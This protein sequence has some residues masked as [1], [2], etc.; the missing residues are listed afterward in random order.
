MTTTRA[1]TRRTILAGAAMQAAPA[2]SPEDE[3]AVERPNLLLLMTDQQSHEAWSGAGNPYL[4]TPAMDSLA[5]RGQ[6]FTNAYCAYPVCSPSRSS[7]FTSRMP[8]ETGVEVNGRSIRAGMPTMGEVFTAAGYQTV[9]AGKWHLPKPFD[10]MTAFEK[11][12]GGSTYGKDMDEP[13]AHA[14]SQWLRRK[15]REPFLM[16]ASFMN[17]H[18]I[19]EW[20]RQHKGTRSHANPRRFPPAPANMGLEAGEPEAVRFHR[21]SGYDTMSQAVAIAA[22]WWKNDVR[23]YLHDYYRMV[24]AVDHHIGTVLEALR[25]S[26]LAAKTV[27]CFTSDHGEGLG[28][29]RWVQ[30]ASL[31]EESV[32]VPFVLAGP[33]VRRGVSERLVSLLDILPTLCGHAGINGPEEMRGLDLRT[34]ASR[35]Y[36]V[37]ELRYRDEQRDGRMVRSERYKYIVFRTGERAEQ[38][39]DLQKDP[40]E[41]VNLAGESSAKQELERHRAMLSEWSRKTGDGFARA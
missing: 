9:Y 33:G 13:V 26:G 20:I 35:P 10:G 18:D 3:A 27:V 29:H 34:E 8:H 30:K 23:E 15:P 25:D 36:V 1:F 37:S 5:A 7:I 14:C 6:V 17:P 16:V 4:K 2:F 21:T 31:Y 19:C 11:L 24:E 28:A 12:V 32:H 38:L 39:F 22:E 41:V 40:G